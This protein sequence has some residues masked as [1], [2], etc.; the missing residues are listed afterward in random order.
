MANQTRDFPT[1][2]DLDILKLKT[3][4]YA[5]VDQALDEV[6][7]RVN[8]HK[9]VTTTNNPTPLTELPHK[10]VKDILK[11]PEPIKPPVLD[12]KA[13]EK[14]HQLLRKME[15]SMNVDNSDYVVDPSK[16]TPRFAQTLLEAKDLME[17][18]KDIPSTKKDPLEESIEVFSK[19][20]TEL[21]SNIVDNSVKK[22]INELRKAG[23][24]Q[25]TNQLS[26][27]KPKTSQ[28]DTDRANQLL[29]RAKAFMDTL[30]DEQLDKIAS[31]YFNHRRRVS[32]LNKETDPG[33]DNFDERELTD[34]HEGDFSHVH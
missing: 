26:Q 2:N 19:S 13:K 22:H 6:I 5:K 28:E 24:L 15:S 21:I 17:R 1:E 11:D 23:L 14:A 18:Q 9:S 25:Y 31:A 8:E 34:L 10:S 32:D 29:S 4:L 3:K 12:E 30:N 16:P 27:E 20:L 7:N 33:D